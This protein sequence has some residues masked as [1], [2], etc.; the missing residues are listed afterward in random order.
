[1]VRTRAAERAGDDLLAAGHHVEQALAARYQ[2]FL[3]LARPTSVLPMIRE[4]T[5]NAD[6][7]ELGLGY[8][9]DDDRRL[10]ELHQHLA[11][12][13]WSMWTE[14]GRSVIAVSDYKRRLVFSS[15]NPAAF[16][17]SLAGLDAVARAYDPDVAG[18]TS[19]IIDGDDPRLAD[20]GLFAAPQTGT[21]LLLARGVAPGGVARAVLA[22]ALDA[23]AVVDELAP[24]EGY[25]VRVAGAAAADG[26]VRAARGVLTLGVPVA[27]PGD[28]QPIAALVVSH[29]LGRGLGLGGRSVAIALAAAGVLGAAA[30]RSRAR[31]F[32]G[33]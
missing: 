19:M 29:P 31:A 33:G 21:L 26:K 2:A 4:I 16:G 30:A 25:S 22:Q 10:A 1:V 13:D 6:R 11:S 32:R 5:G 17:G 3:A 14:A 23:R 9:A 20:S 28:P 24:G 27:G 15:G 7:A 18:V 12:G 8:P